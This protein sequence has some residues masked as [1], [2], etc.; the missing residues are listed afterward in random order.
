[1]RSGSH[2]VMGRLYLDRPS[3]TIRTEFY[4][5]EKGRYL[6]PWAHRP[7][8]HYEAALLQ[9]FPEDYLWCGSKIEIARQIGNAVPV[10]LAKAIAGR[11]YSYLR[12]TGH[13]S[14]PG[15]PGTA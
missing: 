7:I 1:H 10:D 5:P 6:H 4:K 15:S 8:T 13:V 3:V 14:S 11:V 2:D 12:A 9:G